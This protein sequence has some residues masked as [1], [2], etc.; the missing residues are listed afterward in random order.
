MTFTFVP[1]FSARTL[2]N[3]LGIVH[4][5]NTQVEPIRSWSPR[6]KV[7]SR[8]NDVGKGTLDPYRRDPALKIEIQ[9]MI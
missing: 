7:F 8:Q 2:K 9:T 5:T 4:T 1:I 6:S 3:Y